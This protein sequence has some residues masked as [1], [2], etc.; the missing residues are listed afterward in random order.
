[1][2]ERNVERAAAALRAVGVGALPMPTREAGSAGE[3]AREAAVRGCDAV[4]ACG[5]DGTVLDV[6]QG[7]VGTE[8]ALGVVPMGTGNALA[9]DLGIPMHPELA[10]RALAEGECVR[11][12]VGK[13]EFEQRSGG[14]GERYFMSAAGVGADAE[15]MYRLANQFQ[16]GLGMWAYYSEGL[17]VMLGHDFPEFEVE[18]RGEGGARWERVSDLL[19]VRLA[20]FGGLLKRLAPGAE[21]RRDDF[22]LVLAKTRRRWPYFVYSLGVALRRGWV[23][24][25]IELVYATEVEC[26][27]VE[28]MGRVHL[29]ADG[30]SLGT[31]PVRLSIVPQGCVLLKPKAG[32]SK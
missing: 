24:K 18:I 19:A 8:I 26:R 4:I 21:L 20:V 27:A 31:L 15:M 16:R 10:A 29:Q 17:R 32:G 30:E 5:G 3:Q 23:P 14:R 25:E 11:V 28:G 13:A 6:L 22:R 12:A 2:R 1:M 7:V 9:H